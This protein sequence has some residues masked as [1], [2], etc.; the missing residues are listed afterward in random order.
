[1]ALLASYLYVVIALAIWFTNEQ[2][3]DYKDTKHINFFVALF[4]P[5]LVP[6][7]LYVIASEE[8]K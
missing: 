8:G 4:W 2:Y 5:V 3:D 1:M 6:F 7:Y